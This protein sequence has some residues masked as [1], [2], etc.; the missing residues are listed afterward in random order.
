MAKRKTSTAK[1]SASSS[2][3]PEKPAAARRKKVSG[4]TPS[5]PDTKPAKGKKSSKK[6]GPGKKVSTAGLASAWKN[7]RKVKPATMELPDIPDG[8]FC[9]KLTNA[10]YGFKRAPWFRI[11]FTLTA[12]EYIGTKLTKLYTLTDDVINK[13]TGTTQMDLFSMDLQR[14]GI[15]VESLEFEDIQ[16]TL[17]SFLLDPKQHDYAES[18]WELA[19]RNKTDRNGQ[20]RI[21]VYVNSVVEDEQFESWEDTIEE[22]E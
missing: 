10:S 18:N 12:G 7:S 6:G 16:N 13:E 17:A 19:I 21:N 15:D 14:L 3:S 11:E 22:T 4:K 9:G 8:T 5:T 1:T 2:S 20:H